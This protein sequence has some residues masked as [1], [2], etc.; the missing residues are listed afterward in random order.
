MSLQR[1][2]WRFDRVPQ[3]WQPTC[4]SNESG[5]LLAGL[6]DF[7]M[8]GPILSDEASAR[9]TGSLNNRLVP[10][11]ER[12]AEDQPAE[13]H[14]ARHSGSVAVGCGADREELRWLHGARGSRSFG[15]GLEITQGLQYHQV[16][17]HVHS[18]G[19]VRGDDLHLRSPSPARPCREG[20]AS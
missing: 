3:S 5:G 18:R 10:R 4:Y 6:G 14:P 19:R 20:W 15:A 8:E 2:L 17:A 12:F 7:E 9:Q 16:S 13:P 11:I 1:V